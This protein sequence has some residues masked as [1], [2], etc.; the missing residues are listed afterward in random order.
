MIRD[1][2]KTM[3]Y[4]FLQP[5]VMAYD[6]QKHCV[7][8]VFLTIVTYFPILEE[9]TDMLISSIVSFSVISLFA[10]AIEFYQKWFTTDRQ[11]EVNDALYMQITNLV[12][13]SILNLYLILISV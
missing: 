3:G 5:S 8:A 2:I 6:K 7:L 1:Y 13:L 12:V 11:F 9:S 10:W 4:L